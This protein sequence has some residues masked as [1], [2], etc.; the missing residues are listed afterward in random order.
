V[1]NPRRP[2]NSGFTLIELLVVIAIIAILIGLLLPA[3]QKVREAASRLRCQSNLKQIG[4]GLQSYHSAVGYLPPGVARVT[5]QESVSPATFWSFFLLPYIEQTNLYDSIPLVEQP[6]WTT[7][8]YLAALQVPLVIFRCASSPDQP[9]YNSQGIPARIPINYAACQTGSIGN[10][11]S[12]LG[13]SGEWSAHLDDGSWTGTSFD[14]ISTSSLYRFHGALGYNTKTKLVS[15]TDGTSNTVA[16]GERYR[17]LSENFADTYTSSDGGNSCHGTWAIGT[18]N[19]NNKAQQCVGSV[20]VPLNYNKAGTLTGSTDFSKTAG[21][22]SSR[23]SNGVNFVYLDGSVKFLRDST[24]DLVREALVT[25][26]GG[27]SFDPP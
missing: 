7:G 4:I 21:G 10:P 19:I 6:N 26:T 20:G 23:H 12:L 24:P 18:P 25:I 9:T 15:V 17:I 16:I 22:F 5:I 14:I 3:V 2:R 27:E 8:N 1:R 11:G 13:G